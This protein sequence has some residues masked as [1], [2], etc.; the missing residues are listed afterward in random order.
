[1]TK[2]SRLSA[3][4][5]LSL[6]QVFKDKEWEIPEKTED[7][8]SRFCRFCERLSIFEEEEQR[9]II[10]L[11]KRFSEI[12]YEDYLSVALNLLEQ[13]NRTNNTFL[14]SAK[15]LFFFPLLAPDDFTKSKSSKFVW[16]FF[17]SE[18]IKYCRALSNKELYF[19]E[20]DNETSTKKLK[21]DDFIILV[22][23][24]IGTGETAEKAI[25][26]FQEERHIDPSMMVILA[27]AAQN[28]GLEYL[29]NLGVEV[30]SYY[31]FDK[32]ITDYYAGEELEAHIRLMIGIEK[33]LKVRGLFNFG[34]K[35]SEALITLIR[36]PNNT[37]PVFW[38][39]NSKNTANAPFSRG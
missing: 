35:R 38:K 10:E 34:Y 5:F 3:E 4:V 28:I 8:Q 14:V 2:D 15:R 9:L 18:K 19:F 13:I 27:L 20:I 22:D 1:M 36:I 16:Y 29:K 30:Y 32:G 37:F 11:T 26:W 6:V 24:Y 21:S 23:D 31:R 7:S 12:K 17:R 25:K 39:P 33:K